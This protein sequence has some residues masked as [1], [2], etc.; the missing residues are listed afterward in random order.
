MAQHL[1]SPIVRIEN[2]SGDETSSASLSRSAS[3]RSLQSRQSNNHLSP[4]SMEPPDDGNDQSRH[5]RDQAPAPSTL[6]VMSPERNEDGSWVSNDESG[7]AGLGP[8]SRAQM[9]DYFVPSLQELEEQR[10]L[11]EKNEDVSYWLTHSDVGSE[12]GDVDTPARRSRKNANR[13]RAKSTNDVPSNNSSDSRL[14]IPLPTMAPGPPGPGLNINVPSDA[15]E[16][17]DDDDAEYS[18]EEDSDYGGPFSPPAEVFKQTTFPAVDQTSSAAMMRF[19]Q[20]AKDIETSSLAATL[21]SRRLSES[22][23][24]SIR[25]AGGVAKLLAPAPDTGRPTPRPRRGSF[26]SSILPNR[27][28]NNVLKRKNSQPPQPPQASGLGQSSSGEN[29]VET[30]APKRIGSWGRSKSP[31][32]KLDTSVATLGRPYGTN[33][34]TVVTPSGLGARAKD[35]LRRSRSKSDFGKVPGLADLITRHGG[36]PMVTLAS[37][38]NDLLSEQPR[39]GQ[40]AKDEDD[41]DDDDEAGPME[42]I[43]MDLSIRSDPI[44]P[45]LE[46][47]KDHAKTLN[48]RLASYLLERVSQEQ[49]KRYTRL[50]ESKTKHAKGVNNGKCVSKS[51]CFALGGHE[52]QLQPKTPSKD[53]ETPFIGFQIVSPGGTDEDLEIPGEGTIVAAS[54]PQGVPLP[55]VKRL[56]AEFE[57]PLCF[58]VKKFHK[59]SD[60]TKHV[61]EDVQPFTCTFPSCNEPKSFKRKADWVRHENERHR[62]LEY[63]KCSYSDCNHICYRK[64]NF[65]QH[66]VREHKAPEPKVRTGRGATNGKSPIT[67]TGVAWYSGPNANQAPGSTSSFNQTNSTD[68]VWTLVEECRKDTTKEPKDEPCRFCGNICPTWKKLTVHLAKH[69]EQISM[70]ILPLIEGMAVDATAVLS[71]I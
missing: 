54:F 18:P 70:P 46:G 71:P 63:W 28:P 64:D 5:R 20:R 39:A 37:P 45:T 11:A 67:P 17:E 4:Y 51:F 41:S 34:P 36:P 8:E 62:Q 19:M 16:E 55:P 13:R 10:A 31:A 14:A 47:F 38:G 24:G 66:L 27:N 44:V 69:M 40:P 61:H 25:A 21:G 12:G 32:P 2:Y 23:M 33:T 56:P 50:L 60:W 9:N 7:Q 68:Q 42:G 29:I 30:A 52:E 48:P 65:V 57:C 22:D 6:Q 58:K 49:K 1:T 53:S 35:M 26:L 3:R 15:E 43:V 59:P